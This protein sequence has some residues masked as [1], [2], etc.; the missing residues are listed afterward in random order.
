MKILDGT[1]QEIREFYEYHGYD[2]E[3][4]LEI[5]GARLRWVFIPSLLLSICFI[6]IWLFPV[7]LNDALEICFIVGLSLIC[8]LG[9]AIHL[10]W[11]NTTLTVISI[12]FA[13]MMLAVILKILTPREALERIPAFEQS[14]VD[15]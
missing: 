12:V 13:L 5:R 6:V 15:R 7:V 2:L 9:G 8:W 11:R 1:P 14:R 3:K 4:V 10:R